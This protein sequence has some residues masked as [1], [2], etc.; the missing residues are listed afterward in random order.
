MSERRACGAFPINRSTQ[1]YQSRRLDQAGLKMKIK[2]LDT[3]CHW[4]RDCKVDRLGVHASVRDRRV[5]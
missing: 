3:F 2:E 1:R 5:V 4:V